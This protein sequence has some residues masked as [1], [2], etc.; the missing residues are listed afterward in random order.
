MHF[1]DAHDDLATAKKPYRVIACTPVNGRGPLL[2]QTI[3]RLYKKNGVYKVIITGDQP[4][5]RKVCEEAGALWIQHRN[6]PLGQKWNAAFFEA[7][8][9]DPDACLYV[10]SSDWLS[11]NWINVMRPYVDKYDFT[12]TPGMHLLHINNLLRA[13]YWSGYD[14]YRRD[15][16]I[17]IGRMLS[18]H[19]LSKMKWRP[20]NDAA[21]RSLDRSMKDHAARHSIKDY[22]VSDETIKSLAISTEQWTNMHS[23]EDHVSGSLRHQSK[24]ISNVKEFL[25][26]NF[27]EAFTLY[28]QLAGIHKQ[29]FSRT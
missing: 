20:F 13:C 23:Y 7:K 2:K 27:P 26:D 9:F 4:E 1:I 21:D 14:N 11:D 15:E 22:L 24:T 6:R 25:E 10:G 5:D 28:E 19:L 8:Q 3:N 17:G 29:E 16:S 12:G 18:S